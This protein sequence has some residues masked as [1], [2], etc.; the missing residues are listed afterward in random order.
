MKRLTALPR[1]HGATATG[2]LLLGLTALTAAAISAAA[3]QTPVESN[4]PR[5]GR[6]VRLDPRLDKILPPGTQIEVL[7]SG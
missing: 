6:I 4:F 5:L 2:A 1:H 7:A 3:Q